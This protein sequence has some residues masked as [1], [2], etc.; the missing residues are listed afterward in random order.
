[1]SNRF[2]V[3]KY[4]KQNVFFYV[5]LLLFL[6]SLVW[7]RT[8]F[9]DENGICI[10]RIIIVAI[11]WFVMF[12]S[13]FV[14]NKNAI[15]D[16][17]CKNKVLTVVASEVSIIII[18]LLL[19]Q[20]LSIFESNEFIF[21][22]PL[23]VFANGVV[24]YIILKVVYLIGDSIPFAATLVGAIMII[25]C[26]VN[27]YVEA[28]RMNPILPWDVYSI[29]TA[30]AV[31]EEYNV[32]AT[33]EFVKVEMI[34]LLTHEISTYL[35]IKQ[36]RKL[37]DV[38]THIGL[39]IL[40]FVLLII[41]YA[42]LI[43]PHL[44]KSLVS[45]DQEYNKYGTFAG[46]ISYSRYLG[47]V[48]PEN[49]SEDEYNKLWEALAVTPASD[50][51]T[52]TNIIFIM[53]ESL[54]D[55]SIFGNDKL[56]EDYLPYIHSL[57]EDTIK[58]NVVVSVY[59]GNTC[60]SEFEALT[61]C[62]CAWYKT[63]PFLMAI[64]QPTNSIVSE[65]KQN[66]YSA[67]AEHAHF[68]TNWN[69]KAVYNYLGFDRF[70]SLENIPNFDAI[71]KLRGW[72]T[73]KANYKILENEIANDSNNKH[74][75][76]NVTLQNHGG[77]DGPWNGF[78]KTVDLSKN[79]DY[80]RA[81][82]YLTL[83]KKSDEAFKGLVEYYKNVK[84]PTLIVMFGDHHG[85]V[86]G[87]FYEFLYGKSL[88]EVSDEEMIKKYMTPLVVWANYDIEE[89]YYEY[90]SANYLSALILKTANFSMGKYDTFLLNLYN[91]YPVISES[92]VIDCNG[93]YYSDVK[94][95]ND[96][97]LDDYFDLQYGRIEGFEK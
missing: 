80:N 2:E 29:G 41:I 63:L 91:K 85:D 20:I 52:P 89:K 46:L 75:M 74:F 65:M 79:G 38:L 64:N 60:N 45:I 71:E 34:Y 62:S 42:F 88:D 49:F 35:D 90:I 83:M 55:Y 11:I 72:P 10:S 56:E 37:K 12:I 21:S 59:G 19:L 78:N 51:V 30:G 39:S 76:F 27:F 36:E 96:P 5:T 3:K 69:R 33:V 54:C 28:F 43:F 26:G 24:I 40:S 77:Y 70:I 31:A 44:P 73:D 16:K 15:I 94:E 82:N 67:K 23:Y 8:G 86:G 68:S 97:I 50:G 1:M 87:E 25:V 48:E 92:G 57:K 18:A 13:T 47:K 61:G 32:V 93:R 9:I 84:E 53:N 7:T 17:I 4:I 14:K 81:E 66:G 58:G 22:N 6:V 95:V